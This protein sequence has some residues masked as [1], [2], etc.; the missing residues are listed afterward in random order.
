MPT[1]RRTMNSKRTRPI[2]PEQDGE[3]GEEDRPP[4]VPTVAETASL[5]RG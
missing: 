3:P 2:K 1:E 5:M 4:A